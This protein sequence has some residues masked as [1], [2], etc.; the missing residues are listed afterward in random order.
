M[1]FGDFE[2]SIALNINHLQT[3]NS[4]KKTD[5]LN[6]VQTLL[7]TSPSPPDNLKLDNL[8]LC[9]PPTSKL[10]NLPASLNLNTPVRHA[11]A[12]STQSDSPAA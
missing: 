11:N 8:K 3:P 4:R 12:I 6:G 10:D 7:K 9:H 1:T 2:P 5:P